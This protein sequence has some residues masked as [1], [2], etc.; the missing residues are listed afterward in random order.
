[1]KRIVCCA[2]LLMPLLAQA[3]PKEIE[4]QLN[5]SEISASVI[6]IDHNLAGLQLY[7]YGGQAAQCEARFRSGPEA[8]K[9][10]RAEL[11]PG[12]SANFSV[13]FTRSVLRLRVQLT[14]KPL[15]QD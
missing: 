14:C 15:A 7:N 10:R 12:A 4:K 3:F 11:A 9:V 13:R 2:L 8:P 6:A 5:G 1:M